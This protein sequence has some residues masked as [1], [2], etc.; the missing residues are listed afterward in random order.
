MPH[1]RNQTNIPTRTL[2]QKI[3]EAEQIFMRRN[4]NLPNA[5]F[6]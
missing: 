6:K 5:W 1:I 2:F 4:K 3:S